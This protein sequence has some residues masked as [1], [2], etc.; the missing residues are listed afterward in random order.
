MSRRIDKGH[1]HLA[2]YFELILFRAVIMFLWGMALVVFSLAR[3]STA[4]PKRLD[5]QAHI[6]G[7]QQEVA[8][9]AGFS[10]QPLV[11]RRDRSIVS[12]TDPAAV[13]TRGEKH[14]NIADKRTPAASKT[15]DTM[16]C[17]NVYVGN[18]RFLP[19]DY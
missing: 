13:I 19:L 8:S 11:L 4:I 1:I 2:R 10:R 18:W 16:E 12:P 3:S 15:E 14:M 9:H 5:P 7:L 6:L 17:V